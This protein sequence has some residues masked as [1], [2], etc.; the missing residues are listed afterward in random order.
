MDDLIKDN[1]NNIKN[2]E[3]IKKENE[4]KYNMLNNDR[5]LLLKDESKSTKKI[6]E[7]KIVNNN[8]FKNNPYDMPRINKISHNNLNNFHD[9]KRR[10][11]GKSFFRKKIILISVLFKLLLFK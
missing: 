6:P 8:T 9:E 7:I 3:Y 5:E 11:E 10:I 1:L 2:E 4:V